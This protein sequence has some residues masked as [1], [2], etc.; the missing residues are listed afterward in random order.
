MTTATATATRTHHSAAPH[1]PRLND[2][3]QPLPDDGTPF[4]QLL[5]GGLDDGSTDAGLTDATSTAALGT[6]TLPGADTASKDSAPSP[7]ASA[8]AA[9]AAWIGQALAQ[10]N[11]SAVPDASTDTNGST[12]AQSGSPQPTLS[13]LSNPPSGSDAVASADDKSGDTK[14]HTGSHGA[15]RANGHL[16]GAA[17]VTAHGK[18]HDGLPTVASSTAQTIQ[19]AKAALNDANAQ[20]TPNTPTAVAPDPAQG[21]TANAIAVGS[22]NASASSTQS[23]GTDTAA[24]L[25]LVTAAPEHGGSQSQA[26]TGS[27]GGNPQPSFPGAANTAATASGSGTDGTSDSN[28]APTFNQALNQAFDALGAQVSFWSNNQVQQATMDLD[29]GTGDPLKVDVTLHDGKIHLDFKTDDTNTRDALHQNATAVLAD[30][31]TRSGIDLGGVSVGAQNSGRDNA[32]SNNGAAPGARGGLR[33][34]LDA[35]SAGG[36]ATGTAQRLVHSDRA[37]DLYA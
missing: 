10:H 7:D 32:S 22:T 13:G 31:L 4:A 20:R 3:G 16:L 24:P 9:M 5:A 15:K 26:Q 33:R 11:G 35:A 18:A 25:T 2:K 29:T 17:T 8:D 28:V 36:T 23:G 21:A 19:A 34:A 27:E 30:L 37:L 6:K 12:G 1:S 14:G